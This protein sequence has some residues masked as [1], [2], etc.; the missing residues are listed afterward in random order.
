MRA[1]LIDPWTRTISG[2]DH[3]GDYREIYKFLDGRKTLGKAWPHDVDNFDI[4]RLDR[5]DGIYVDGE[6]LL[7]DGPAA[8][9]KVGE[10]ELVGRGLVLGCDDEGNSTKPLL[11]LHHL[12]GMVEWGRTGT[13]GRDATDDELANILS[14]ALHGTLFESAP[15]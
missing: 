1:Y 3:T 6:G 10:W 12:R 4:V 11:P 5:G 2:V 9:F 13:R 14:L 15:A 7:K 8:T